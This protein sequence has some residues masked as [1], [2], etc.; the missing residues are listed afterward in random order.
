MRNQALVVQGDPRPPLLSLAVLMRAGFKPD[1][2]AGTPTDAQ[3][4]GHLTAPSGEI[5]KMRFEDNLWRIPMWGEA[6][7]AN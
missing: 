2:K 1:F 3:D 6:K 5:I 4:G 7:A